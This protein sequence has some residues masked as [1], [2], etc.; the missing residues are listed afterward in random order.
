MG[1]KSNG[2]EADKRRAAKLVVERRVQ[3]RYR[4]GGTRLG[5]R[6]SCERSRGG[7]NP[8]YSNSATFELA[9]S[10]DSTDELLT[11]ALKGL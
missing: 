3:G 2:G 1:A 11:W 10:T 8:Q 9:Y 5:R 6:G 7:P 4:P